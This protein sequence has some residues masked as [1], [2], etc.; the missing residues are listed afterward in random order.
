MC[1][2]KPIQLVLSTFPSFFLVASPFLS[3]FLITQ[4][5]NWSLWVA[6]LQ[7]FLC[8]FCYSSWPIYTNNSPRSHLNPVGLAPSC[9]VTCQRCSLGWASSLFMSRHIQTGWQML[10]W[11]TLHHCRGLYLCN[12]KWEI[13]KWNDHGLIVGFKL[14]SHKPWCCMSPAWHPQWS[15]T[16]FCGLTM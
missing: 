2:R 1:L 13:Q 4:I 6:E 15:C 8:A 3:W 5:R 14:R 7:D 16:N 12:Q 11:H 9:G 10:G